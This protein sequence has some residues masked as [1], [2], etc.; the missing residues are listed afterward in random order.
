MAIHLFC[1]IHLRYNFD[2]INIKY[3][4]QRF[5]FHFKFYENSFNSYYVLNDH[6]K[7][8]TSYIESVNTDAEFITGYAESV[9]P[10]ADADYSI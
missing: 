5:I 7:N 9:S 10:Y 6:I 8:F 3:S 2:Y 4:L 1:P